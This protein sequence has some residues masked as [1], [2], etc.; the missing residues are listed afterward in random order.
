[1][2]EF[3]INS[4][5]SEVEKYISKL[6]LFYND[7]NKNHVYID[8]LIE[9]KPECFRSKHHL[10]TNFKPL[11]DKI[12]KELG[13]QPVE[14]EDTYKDQQLFQVKAVL[15]GSYE[16]IKGWVLEKSLEEYN[17][18][19]EPLKIITY[20]YKNNENIFHNVRKDRFFVVPTNHYDINGNTIFEDDIVELQVDF[21]EIEST[22][23]NRIHK[24][25]KLFGKVYGERD[26]D[27]IVKINLPLVEKTI[28]IPL[29][30]INID[31][32]KI[33]TLDD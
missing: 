33:T 17:F 8:I 1:M 18:T 5:A 26:M 20:D 9:K 14:L 32:Y 22:T 13:I 7:N 16:P 28:E 10:A 15:E 4:E 2:K 25:I 29:N 30:S 24:T 3:N 31:K 23:K 6:G 21:N 11:S 27:K 19:K 12:I